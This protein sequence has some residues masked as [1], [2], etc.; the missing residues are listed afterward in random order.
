MLSPLHLT[1]QDGELSREEIESRGH[2]VQ[3]RQGEH[4]PVNQINLSL[5]K[6]LWWN[7]TSFPVQPKRSDF[8]DT[9][10]LIS[11]ESPQTF[12]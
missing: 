7:F 2:G 1:R 4:E 8:R 5:I 12:P 9:S 10:V 3:V 6:I 11:S